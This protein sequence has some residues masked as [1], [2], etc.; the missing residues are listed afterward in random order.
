MKSKF[1]DMRTLFTEIGGSIPFYTAESWVKVKLRLETAGPVAVSTRSEI[2]PVLGG[3][4]AL[5]ND[6][7]TVFVLSKGDMLYYTAQAVNRV[8]FITEPHTTEVIDT[9][10]EA[11]VPVPPNPMTPKRKPSRIVK[12][13]K[14]NRW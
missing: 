11:P 1:T 7:D 3:N 4:G 14:P 2:E 10:P 13:S 12:R 9:K 6:V 8:R 5:L